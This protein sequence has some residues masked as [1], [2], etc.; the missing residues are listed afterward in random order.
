MQQFLEVFSELKGKN[1]YLTGESVSIGLIFATFRR[2]SDLCKSSMRECMCHV[3]RYRLV[4]VDGIGSI[5]YPDIANHIYNNPTQ[6]DL[7]LKGI[8]ISD[9]ECLLLLPGICDLNRSS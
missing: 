1:L 8:W 5:K 3:S 9:R 7:N 2:V 6:L 4:D